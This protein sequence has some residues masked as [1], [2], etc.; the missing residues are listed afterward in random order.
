MA[1]TVENIQLDVDIILKTTSSPAY[2]ASMIK[3]VATNHIDHERNEVPVESR[4]CMRRTTCGTY[5][6]AASPVPT[7]PS[8][9][10]IRVGAFPR[11]KNKCVLKNYFKCDI[12]A[13]GLGRAEKSA[14]LEEYE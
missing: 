7:M 10:N 13:I 3:V 12:F 11:V 4:V 8:T 14:K 5:A 9:S 1:I 6:A 2:A